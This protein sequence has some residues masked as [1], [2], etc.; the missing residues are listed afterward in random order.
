MMT[1]LAFPF[2]KALMDCLYPNK[3]FPD[4]MTRANLE[5]MLSTPFFYNGENTTK[6]LNPDVAVL[7]QVH[8]AS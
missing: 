5:L 4:F 6:K 8:T 7:L 2:L 3:T 1:N